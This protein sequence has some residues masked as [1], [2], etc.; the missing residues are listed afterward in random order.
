V[1]IYRSMSNTHSKTNILLA[2]L[3]T[4]AVAFFFFEWIISPQTPLTIGGAEITY[5]LAD[6]ESERSKG[7]SGRLSL[8][9]KEGMLFVFDSPDMY[10]FWMKDMK[11]PIDFIWIDEN[12]Q[13]IGF[14]E[15]ISPN[16][17]PE[18]FSPPSPVKYVL[19]VN[20]GFVE[21]F[22]I[23]VGMKVGF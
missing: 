21:K 15:N 3:V 7:L 23:T 1:L 17:Y 6:I 14:L 10:S 19:E 22:G 16:T 5:E 11:F 8:S 2:V 13:V 9:Q 4:M 12:R 20:S 18:T